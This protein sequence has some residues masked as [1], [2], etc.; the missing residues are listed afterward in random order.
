M[1]AAS[2]TAVRE[3][4]MIN[5]HPG[6]CRVCDVPVTHPAQ[7]CEDHRPAKSAP[8][9]KHRRRQPERSEAE[10]VTSAGSASPTARDVVHALPPPPKRVT[11]EATA[12]F[13]GTVLFYLALF[14]VMGFVDR[15]VPD[16]PEER[17]E[18]HV[19]DLQLTKEGANKIAKPL[20]RF[21]T[22]VGMWQRVG[23]ALVGNTD[24]I[25]ALVEL[26]DWLSALIRFRRRAG[27][28]EASTAPIVE[29]AMNGAAW[30]A[31]PNWGNMPSDSEIARIRKEHGAN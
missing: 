11:Q 13:F 12:K 10:P 29:P 30:H 25:D 23:P 31:S 8:G 3:P 4:A 2:A 27:R 21:I 1:S 15:A 17:K 14:L 5:P 22:P 18:A 28:A 6:H 24:A 26:Y 9:R 20:A 7:Y 19:A 16:E